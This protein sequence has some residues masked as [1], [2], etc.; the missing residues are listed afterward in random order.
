MAGTVVVVG[1]IAFGM[2]LGGGGTAPAGADTL[3]LDKVRTELLHGYY[4]PVPANV[5][6]QPSVSAMLGALQD[7]YT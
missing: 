7:P 4:R 1:A 6:R 5:L 3:L 2:S